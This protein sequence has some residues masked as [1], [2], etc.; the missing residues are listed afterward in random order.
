MQM[1]T[2]IKKQV[3]HLKEHW[4]PQLKNFVLDLG[5]VDGHRDYTKFIVLGRS[6]SGSNLLR[7]LLNANSQVVTY[8]EMFK[9]PQTIGWDFPG[10]PQSGKVLER[11]QH[12]PIDFMEQDLFKKMPKSVGAVGFKIFYYHAYGTGLEPVWQYLKSHQEV[13]VL[14]IKRQNILKTHL[15]RVR[16]SVTDSWINL[17]GEEEEAPAVELNYAECLA[18]FQQTRAWEE[19]HDQMFSSHP[20]MEIIYEDL[21]RNYAERMAEIFRFLGVEFQPVQPQTYKQ[22][23]KKLSESIS[24]YW[25][26]KSQFAGSP[27]ETFFTE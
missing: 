24:N 18:D 1:L 23:S 25:T 9:D 12:Q 15:S 22:T 3:F 21:A 4:S 26:L 27:W 10:T 13:H 7:G 19:E 6:R 5:L 2:S 17:T 14:H 20:L 11:F 8:S 16:A